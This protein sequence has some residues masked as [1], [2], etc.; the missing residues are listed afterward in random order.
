MPV[1]PV[2]T[3]ARAMRR[4]GLVSFLAVLHFLAAVV[5]SLGVLAFVLSGQ[6]TLEDWVF[7]A[8]L[9]VFALLTAA[10]GWGL[11]NLTPWGRILQIALAILGLLLFPICTH[12]PILL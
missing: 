7:A 8:V 1:P 12:I 6:R 2:M 3:P 11:W 5:Y 10:C 4:P 9:A